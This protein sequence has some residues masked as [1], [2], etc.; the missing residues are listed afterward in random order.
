MK[1]LNAKMI[2]ALLLMP[3]A[4]SL[5]ACVT[6]CP[7]PVETTTSYPAM[8]SLSEPLPSGKYSDSAQTDAKCYRSVVT[9]TS[10]TCAP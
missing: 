7:K 2:Y 4:A 5:T 6:T 3:L 10:T 8:P 1:P 9:G